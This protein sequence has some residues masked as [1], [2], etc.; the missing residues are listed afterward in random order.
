MR[1]TILA[2]VL[3]AALLAAAC[4][5]VAADRRDAGG[6]P[7][8]GREVVEK[9]MEIVG[10]PEFEGSE[11]DE[12]GM[13]LLLANLL[14]DFVD[15]VKRLRRTNGLLYWTLVGW[16]ATTMLVILGHL[17]WTVW[18][19]GR[20]GGRGR[21]AG[22]LLLDP[23]LATRAGRDPDR[24]LARADAAA[25]AGRREEAVPWLYLALLFRLERAGRVEFDAAKTGL[26]VADDLARR[27]ADRRRWLDLL[28]LHDPVVFGNRPCA[29][30]R[31]ASIRRLAVDPLPEEAPRGD[32]R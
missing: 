15:E 8:N 14:S 19:S 27:A 20:G 26:E 32:A 28:D 30:D 13:L 16:L 17:A 2:A 4:P 10:R 7:P 3:G 9:V 24:M 5:A 31:L 6:P 1:A 25:A 11:D 23:A 29:P 18:T 22:A 21:G 12:E